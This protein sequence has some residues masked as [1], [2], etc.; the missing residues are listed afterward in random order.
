MRREQRTVPDVFRGTGILVIIDIPICQIGQLAEKGQRAYLK[1][2]Q[3]GEESEFERRCLNQSLHHEVQLPRAS[4][5]LPCPVPQQSRG[6]GRSN[7]DPQEFHRAD[8]WAQEVGG[9][10][11]GDGNAPW[12][13]TCGLLGSRLTKSQEQGMLGAHSAGP[14]QGPGAQS[15]PI[16]LLRHQLVL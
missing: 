3:H 2:H 13:S 1:S 5:V 8:S 10:W 4:A 11:S 16:P 15:Q 7:L 12:Q 14:L 9:V 6:W